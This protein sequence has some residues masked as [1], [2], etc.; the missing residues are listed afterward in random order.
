MR[1]LENAAYCLIQSG[2]SFVLSVIRRK[3][4]TGPRI[5]RYPHT[6][7]PS[8]YDSREF[9]KRGPIQHGKAGDVLLVLD[10]GSIP[11]YEM[12]GYQNIIAIGYHSIGDEWLGLLK[13]MQRS[14]EP[15]ALIFSYM[16]RDGVLPQPKWEL[17]HQSTL[18]G[19][20]GHFWR[21]T[22]S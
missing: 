7:A 17:L 16:A 15:G 11:F 3:K 21:H 20:K 12:S 22:G 1:N 6:S 8:V 19:H 14:P 2:A 18:R 9:N 4:V 10:P 13:R 5:L